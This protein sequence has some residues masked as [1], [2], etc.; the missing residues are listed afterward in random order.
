MFIDLKA[1]ERLKHCL[2]LFAFLCSGAC[3]GFTYAFW[4][5]YFNP[6]LAISA[7]R[8]SIPHKNMSHKT[9]F[10]LQNV[11]M[12]AS[13]TTSAL[14]LIKLKNWKLVRIICMM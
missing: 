3:D 1:K 4:F 5:T 13:A 8:F 7:G 10:K 6:F 2:Y 12:W 14:G 9:D 11:C